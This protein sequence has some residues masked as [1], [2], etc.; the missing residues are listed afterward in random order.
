MRLS[1]RSP[2]TPEGLGGIALTIDKVRIEGG[3][4]RNEVLLQLC[5]AAVLV[6]L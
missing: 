4:R 1:P 2:A 5:T 6:Q 3:I